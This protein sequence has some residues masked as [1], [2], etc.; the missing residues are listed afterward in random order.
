MTQAGDDPG[1]NRSRDRDPEPPLEGG[2]LC[3]ALRY[4]VAR[5]AELCVYCCHCRDC[6]RLSSSAFAVCMVLPVAAFALRQGE[7]AGVVRRA[8]SGREI[9]GFF[10]AGCGTRLFD[11]FGA[12][13][14][15]MV[16]KAG[17][18]DDTR[19]LEPVAQFWT[20][21]K[22]DWV[23]L[24]PDQLLDPCQPDGFETVIA[25]YQSRRGAPS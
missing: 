20:S 14:D 22:Q 25:R 1:M 15:I 17:T 18:L 2:C 5:N 7:P 10:C 13:P 3:G 19:G 16:L 12:L 21:R 11:R 6:Q 24:P 4:R 8:D 23:A 9:H